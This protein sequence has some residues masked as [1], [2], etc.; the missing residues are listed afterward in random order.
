MESETTNTCTK[1]SDTKEERYNTINWI[2]NE[3]LD[4]Q[5]DMFPYSD[6]ETL[7]LI[8]EICTGCEVREI[9]IKMEG[10]W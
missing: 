1:V 6:S 4:S 7:R 9:Q 5:K 10:L 2:V 8:A 3:W